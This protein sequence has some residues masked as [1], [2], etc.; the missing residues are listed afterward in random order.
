MFFRTLRSFNRSDLQYRRQVAS[1]YQDLLQTHM[2]H[3]R[4]TARFFDIHLK[5]D[6]HNL[7]HTH[8][9]YM[10]TLF[11]EYEKLLGESSDD[12]GGVEEVH[13]I[14]MKTYSLPPVPSKI[15]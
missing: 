2:N 7:L 12:T 13:D 6:S 8:M 11:S 1:D 10:A 9:D 3:I 14:F 15:S 4:Q 5:K